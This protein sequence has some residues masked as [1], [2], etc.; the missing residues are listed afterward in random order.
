MNFFKSIKNGIFFFVLFSV[1]ISIVSYLIQYQVGKDSLIKEISE[2]SRYVFNQKRDYIQTYMLEVDNHVASLIANRTFNNFLTNPTELNS[3]R[4]ADL[5]SA[6]I[7]ANKYF[8]QVRYI[9]Q[10]GK[11]VVRVDKDLQSFDV[12]IVE[13]KELQN[14]SNRYYFRETSK[15]THG[16]YYHSKVDLNIENGKLSIPLTPTFRVASPVIFNGK[17][18]GIIILN[19]EIGRLLENIVESQNFNTYLIDGDGYIIYSNNS[20]L[21]F[22]KYLDKDKDKDKIKIYSIFNDL[23]DDKFTEE[24]IDTDSHIYVHSLETQFK[25]RENIKYIISPSE[26]FLNHLHQDN[27]EASIYTTLILMIFAIPVAILISIPATRLEQKVNILYRDKPKICGH[28]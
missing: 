17:F 8:F 23:I 14:K 11:E 22:S 19:I 7:L 27:I 28:Y 13:G 5:F 10:N 20:S 3:E 12:K 16:S 4:V 18:S 2:Q 1:I 24:K 9:D 15:Y 6:F 21:N 26:E 25:N